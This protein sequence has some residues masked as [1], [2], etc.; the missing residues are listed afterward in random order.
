MAGKEVLPLSATFGC[1][2]AAK[3]LVKSIFFSFLSRRR[4]LT[5]VDGTIV[6][7][8]TWAFFVVTHTQEE[9]CR[10]VNIAMG[11]SSMHGLMMN[12]ADEKNN[13]KEEGRRR[14]TAENK[15]C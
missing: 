5:R 10:M 13:R 15:L 11:A 12:G 6:L 9:A 4:D 8:S 2:Y 1:N 3:H 7:S 14:R